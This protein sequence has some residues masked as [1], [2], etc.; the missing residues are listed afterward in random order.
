MKRLIVDMD[1][2]LADA[3]GQFIKI[4]KAD[5]GLIVDRE[6]LNHKQEGTGFPLEREILTGYA[7]KE[8]FFR[9]MEVKENSQRVLEKLNRQY[10]LFIV[11]SAMEFPLSLYEKLEWLKEHF[12]F[13]HW[14]QIVF[15]GKKS[16]VHGDFMIDDLPHNLE[17]FNGHKFLF[18]APH[19]LQFNQF[20]RLNDWKEVGERLL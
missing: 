14:K 16:I 15:C 10:E 13:L 7:L 2:V 20:E 1:D 17:T 6:S 5:R 4:I 19:N 3:T 18:T 11:S 8:M 9:S 12:P